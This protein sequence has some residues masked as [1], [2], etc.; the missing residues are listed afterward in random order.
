MEEG[1][2]RDAMSI[3]NN[4]DIEKDKDARPPCSALP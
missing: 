2:E 1:G 4:D 3:W